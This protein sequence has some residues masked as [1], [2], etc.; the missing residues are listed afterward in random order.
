VSLLVTTTLTRATVVAPPS[1][2]QRTIDPATG[3]AITMTAGAP[4]TASF[5]IA[6]GQLTIRKDVLLGR[7][8][9]TI[10]SGSDRVSI[11][12]DRTGIVVTTRAGA[13]L[14]SVRHPETMSRIVAALAES[15]SVSE[16]AALLS[17]LR[18]D[19][20]STTGQ[21][22][23]LTKALLQSVSGD[24]RGT[25]EVVSW[26]GPIWRHP[27]VVAARVGSTDSDCW[28]AYT[29][30]ALQAANDYADCYSSTSWY[31]VI[32]RLGC[33]ALYDVAAESNWVGYLNCAASS[34]P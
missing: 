30:A 11:I 8:V 4:G 27:R 17:R 33:S 31:D 6:Q 9:T 29:A 21:A 13:A 5:E 3:L 19:P 20:A 23:T 2:S 12:I 26:T 16:A 24:R 22:L 28:G 32:G 1:T 14:A 10:T 34:T 18:L 15:A 7:S 25:L